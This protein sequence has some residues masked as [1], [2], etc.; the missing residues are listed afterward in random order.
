[1]ILNMFRC[2]AGKLIRLS[3][4]PSGMCIRSLCPV[5]ERNCLSVYFTFVFFIAFFVRIITEG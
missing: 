1:M 5:G 3:F 2:V 4:Q